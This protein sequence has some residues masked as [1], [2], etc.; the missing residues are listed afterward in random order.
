MGLDMYLNRYPRYKHYS[1]KDI[2]TF[3]SHFDY[4]TEPMAKRYTFEEW[5]GCK[6]EDLP[7]EK[8]RPYLQQFIT[9]K[10]GSW[11]NDHKYPH[12]Q[13]H[14]NV[15]YWRKANHIHKWFVDNI[16]DGEDD[17]GYHREVTERDLRRL[18]DICKV[19][20]DNVVLKEGKVKNGYRFQNGKEIPIFEDGKVVLNPDLC[21]ALLPTDDGFFFG[22]TDYDH[23]YVED[24]KY[25]YETLAKVLE[26]TD[27]ETEML[28]Y[29]SS[30]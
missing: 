3:D 16:Q 12:N 13:I 30:W 24:I 4:L 9:T 20:L 11:D 2:D 7:A 22:S 5:C 8:D 29:R 27:F 10:Y 15:A 14:E 21:S 25:T 26:E 23:W 19:I 1:P 18:L 6:E 28:F 17:C